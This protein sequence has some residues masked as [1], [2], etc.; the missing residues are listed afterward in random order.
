M[1]LAIY[2]EWDLLMW[3]MSQT[4]HAKLKDLLVVIVADSS[5]SSS[6]SSATAR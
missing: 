1:D 5:S 4:V 6:S 2:M 3:M